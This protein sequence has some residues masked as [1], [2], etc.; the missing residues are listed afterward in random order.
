MVTS[1]S[2]CLTAIA[3]SI[4]RQTETIRLAEITS[5]LP[6]PT[7]STP[8]IPCSASHWEAPHEIRI[9]ERKATPPAIL[10]CDV[11]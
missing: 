3:A 9:G 1:A 2:S 4:T 10:L 8:P 11:R 5:A 6:R 7:S